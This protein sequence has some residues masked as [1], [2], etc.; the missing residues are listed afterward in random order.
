M[1]RVL[2]FGLIFLC[3]DFTQI[4]GH[5]IF[6][7]TSVS[8]IMNEPRSFMLCGAS[9]IHGI[10]GHRVH[11]EDHSDPLYSVKRTKDRGGPRN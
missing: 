6:Y 11:E 10:N 7:V 5:G 9:E 1:R 2:K 4:H 8:W 3:Q